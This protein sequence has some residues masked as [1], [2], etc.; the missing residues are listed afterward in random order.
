MRLA[1]SLPSCALRR[2]PTF[3]LHDWTAVDLGGG[4]SGQSG[5]GGE[6]GSPLSRLSWTALETLLE[7][8]LLRRCTL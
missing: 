5:Q 1:S 6:G 7:T 4:Q 3:P 8:L 2:F